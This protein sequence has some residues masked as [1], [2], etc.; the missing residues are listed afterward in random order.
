MYKFTPVFSEPQE[1]P[2]RVLFKYLR[3]PGMI[4]FAGGYPDPELF[5]VEGLREAGE[6]AYSDVRSCLEYGSSDGI[7]KLK[8]EIIRLMDA[9]RAV[10]APENIVVTTGSQ[11]GFDLLLRVFVSPGDLVFVEQ[12]T[13]PANLQALR[14]YGARVRSVPIDDDGMDVDALE[15]MLKSLGQGERPKFVYTVPTFG[16]PSGAT[17]SRQRRLRLLQLAAEYAF[18]IVEDDPYSQLRFSGE[19]VDSLLA[20]ADQVP[21]AAPWVVHLTSLSKVVAPGLRVAWL[22]APVEIARRCAV[23]KQSADIGSSPW[24]Q[25]IAAEYLAGGRMDSQLSTIVAVY[26]AKCRALAAAVRNTLGDAVTF[27]EPAG[28]MFLWARLNG[29]VSAAELLQ[30]SIARKVLFVPGEGFQAENAD[31][32]TLRLSFTNPALEEIEQGVARLHGAFRAVQAVRQGA[33]AVE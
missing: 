28:G 21:G 7:R 29:G 30:A 32:A 15:D 20:L 12:T 33:A 2:I 13:Y 11:Q 3:E 10:I 17:L 25:A 27:Q 14:T 4:S 18:V 31:P 24:T 8:D 1:S 23:A 9:R 19:P 22:I 5:D 26:G 16:N 6:R